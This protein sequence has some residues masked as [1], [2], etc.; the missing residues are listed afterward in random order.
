[1]ENGIRYILSKNYILQ[2]PRRVGKWL[3]YQIGRRYCAP[4]AVVS[5]HR[6][7]NFL[8]FSVITGGKGRVLVNGDARDVSAGDIHL[9]FPSDLHEIR[10]DTKEPLCYDFLS[11]WESENTGE[12]AETVA[13][14]RAL[15]KSVL[16]NARMGQL[17]A[18]AID[19]VNAAKQGEDA[20][21]EPLIDLIFAY[22]RRSLY[23]NNN[24]DLHTVS[25]AEQLSYRVMSYIDKNLASIRR[26]PEVARALNYNYG[27]LSALFRRTTGRN[28]IA[29]YNERR[30][31]AADTR[32]RA[33]MSVSEVALQLGYASPYSFSR[34]YRAYF[35]FPPSVTRLA[36]KRAKQ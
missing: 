1:M 31:A 7:E 26:L 32:L 16:N 9:S 35:G 6:H 30:F 36:A 25:G 18:Y 4:G 8:E 3:I 10:S 15:G 33:G 20:V 22:A 34:A 21:L 17:L 13:F 2:E 12:T 11:I 14:A 5:A 19:E 28:M 29:Y 24:G 27:Y 23:E